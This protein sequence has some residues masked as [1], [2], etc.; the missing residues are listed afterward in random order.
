[1]ETTAIYCHEQNVGLVTCKPMIN[2]TNIARFHWLDIAQK[3]IN[4]PGS[5]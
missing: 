5:L 4:L 1:M 2:I 3:E